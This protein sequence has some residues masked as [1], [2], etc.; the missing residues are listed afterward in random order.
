MQECLKHPDYFQTAKL[1]TI[2]DLF[3][4]RVHLGHRKGTLNSYMLPFIF[5]SRL[6]N[7]IIDL[8]QTAPLLQ[9]AL[10]FIAH[11]AL[12]NGLIVFAGRHPESQVRYLA[13]KTT[14]TL[15]ILHSNFFI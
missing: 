11:I 4:A 13:K 12:R 1:F 15:F 5:G 3:N 14:N 6:D 8:D 10:N 2:Q 7:L 9:E